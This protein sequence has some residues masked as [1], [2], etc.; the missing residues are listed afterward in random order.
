MSGGMCCSSSRMA[1]MEAEGAQSFTVSLREP[2]VD[3]L[4]LSFH[5]KT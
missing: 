1:G 3:A 5:S 4:C 2:L